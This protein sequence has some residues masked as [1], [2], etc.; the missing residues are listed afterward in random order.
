MAHKHTPGPWGIRYDYVVQAQSFDGGRLVPVAQPY[1]VNGDGTDLFANARLI[2]A[3][4]ELLEAL[5]IAQAFMAGF[6]DDESQAGIQDNLRQ[7]RAAISKATSPAQAGPLQGAVSHH[8]GDRH[9][10]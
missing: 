9:G 7:I 1:G 8:F 2:A 4:P 3:A 10:R 5:E 6:E